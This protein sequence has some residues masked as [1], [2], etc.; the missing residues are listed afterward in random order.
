MTKNMNF[1]FSPYFEN[2][3]TYYS[4][5]KVLSR[6]SYGK[7]DYFNCN[8]RILLAAITQFKNDRDELGRVGPER[9]WRRSL[10]ITK[11]TWLLSF[12]SYAFGEVWGFVRFISSILSYSMR[13]R[14]CVVEDYGKENIDKSKISIHSSPTRGTFILSGKVLFACTWGLQSCWALSCLLSAFYGWM[15]YST[16]L[17]ERYKEIFKTRISS[18]HQEEKHQSYLSGIVEW[19]ANIYLLIVL[20]SHVR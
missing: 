9:K 16:I 2:I 18:S 7:T 5:C 11:R 13:G 14:H 10:N 12:N 4:P 17:W 15:F 8:F 1:L 19:W 3:S 20:T 6:N